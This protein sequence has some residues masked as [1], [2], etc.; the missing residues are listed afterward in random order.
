MSNNVRSFETEFKLEPDESRLHC[1][2][3][4]ANLKKIQD[5]GRHRHEQVCIEFD[6]INSGTTSAIYRVSAFHPDETSVILGNELESF[7]LLSFQ[8]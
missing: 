2:H 8:K 3:C 5:I 4:K 1:E 7:N 6:T